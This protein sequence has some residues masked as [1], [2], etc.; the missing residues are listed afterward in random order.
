ML[1]ESVTRKLLESVGAKSYHF[2]SIVLHR[3]EQPT[4]VVTVLVVIS[5]SES[6]Q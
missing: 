6:E 1:A 5:I 3:A 4:L 2:C